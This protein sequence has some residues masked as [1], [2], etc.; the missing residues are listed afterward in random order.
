M[1]KKPFKVQRLFVISFVSISTLLFV[2]CK[3]YAF[4]LDEVSEQS[5]CYQEMERTF[6]VHLPENYD[7]TQQYPLIFVLHGITSRAIAIAGYSGFNELADENEFIVCYPQGYKR[8]WGIDIPVG[9][10]P[11]EGIDDIGFIDRIIDTL[12]N[13]Y[14]V[15]D[16]RIYSCGISNGAFM[17]MSLACHL[18][19]RSAGIALVC[20]N[21]FDPP[22]QYC[23]G[24]P[25]MPVLL[26]AG[27]KDPLLEFDGSNIN[28]KYRTA[29]YPKTVDFWIDR[30]N[31]A[32][33]C[34]SVVID[35]DPKD[36]TSVIKNYYYGSNMDEEVVLYRIVGGGH[37]WPGRGKDIKSLLLGKISNEVNASE[38]ITDFFLKH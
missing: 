32:Y 23:D 34:D 1:Y 4:V 10:A 19:G 35:N 27:T 38:I 5:F 33:P 15:N 17:S 2:S 20:G 12:S 25:P 13:A 9:P 31:C 37:A 3:K 16:Q 14:S 21:M 22:A 8:S 30:N 36:K 6:L 18:P 28:K 24:G 7:S 26:M 29:G 11:K